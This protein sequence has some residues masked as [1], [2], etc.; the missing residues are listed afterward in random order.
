MP[1]TLYLSLQIPD[2]L[3]LSFIAEVIENDGVR[4]ADQFNKLA[5]NTSSISVSLYL[6][7]AEL[8]ADA[9]LQK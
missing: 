8:I 2:A 6:S 7:A 4:A 9:F 3:Y 5:L 1:D